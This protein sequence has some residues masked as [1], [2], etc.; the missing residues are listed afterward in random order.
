MK[1]T[2]EIP[3]ALFQVI[4]T[5]AQERGQQFEVALQDVLQQGLAG[6]APPPAQPADNPPAPRIAI[7]PLTG[8]PYLDCSD[9]PPPD[10]QVDPATGLMVIANVT[11]PAPG[12]NLTPE[13]IAEI[14][15]EQEVEWHHEATR[16]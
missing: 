7:H 16:R 2:V 14:L 5:R 3:D 11:P 15:L 4:A 9:L 10:F 13:R 12:D 8:L 6:S 1:T